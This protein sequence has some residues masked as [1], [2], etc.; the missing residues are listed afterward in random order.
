MWTVGESEKSIL[1]GLGGEESLFERSTITEPSQNDASRAEFL[2][3]TGTSAPFHCAEMTCRAPAAVQ[4]D[5]GAAAPPQHRKS[6]RR[7]SLCTTPHAMRGPEL[8]VG[9]VW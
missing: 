7:Q 4:K 9:C 2:S 6:A 3:G 1:D 5:A 8:P